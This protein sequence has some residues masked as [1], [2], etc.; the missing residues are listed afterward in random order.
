MSAL[1]VCDLEGDWRAAPDWV[2]R[3]GDAAVWDGED[4]LDGDAWP[5]S[6]PN[7]E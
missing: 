2:T 1:Q 4:V 3:R 7:A 6:S 5:R